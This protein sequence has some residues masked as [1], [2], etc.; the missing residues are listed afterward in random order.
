MDQFP[1]PSVSAPK[2]PKL[3]RGDNSG[4]KPWS[5]GRRSQRGYSGLRSDEHAQENE[6]FAGRFSLDDDEDEDLT[7]TGAEDAR[8][9]GGET[10]AWRGQ[11]SNGTEGQ[12]K[13]GVHQGLVDV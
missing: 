5:F 4:P 11:R 12:S 8:A 13:V 7:G 6:S 10:D 2:L 1:V 3:G 9:L